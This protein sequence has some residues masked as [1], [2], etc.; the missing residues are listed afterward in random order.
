[1][2]N[3]ACMFYAFYCFYNGIR[4]QVFGRSLP[5][6]V[7]NVSRFK[8]YIVSISSKYSFYE[9]DFLFYVDLCNLHV[10]NFSTITK[11]GNLIYP[12]LYD[13]YMYIFCLFQV[14]LFLELVWPIIIFLIVTLVRQS[15]P[16]STNDAC[17]FTVTFAYGDDILNW[18]WKSWI[19]VSPG[20]FILKKHGS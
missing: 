2:C 18:K 16:P 6:K 13:N 12:L 11:I 14:I 9:T 3:S 5:Q 20:S 4:W 19:W 17:K 7:Q 15:V 1:M 10:C 8:F